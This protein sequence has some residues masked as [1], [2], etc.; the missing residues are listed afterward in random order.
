MG[1]DVLARLTTELGGRPPGGLARLDAASAEDLTRALREAKR[2]QSRE[3]E[4]AMRSSMD[5]VPRLLRGPT[6]KLLFG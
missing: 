5:H 6:R 3:L 2:R 4:S 1:D